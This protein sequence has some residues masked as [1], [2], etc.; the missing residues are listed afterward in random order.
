M[1]RMTRTLSVVVALPLA[2]MLSGCSTPKGETTDERRTYARE[3]V[4]ESLRMLYAERPDLERF[5]ENA[6]GY[7]AFST[8]GTNIIFVSTGGGFGMVRDNAT[9]EETFMRMGEAG[10]GLGLG[11]KDFRAIFVFN[12]QRA[13]DR[14]VDDG[15]TFGADADAAAKTGDQGGAAG[16]KGAIGDEI[17]VYQLT[18]NGLALSAT[19]SGTKYWKDDELN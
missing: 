3:M 17:T 2:L 6:A 15:W 7:G 5:V 9:G 8:I 14:F 12:T 13:L 18:E 10:V 1:A 4:D 16:A 11:V 19:V